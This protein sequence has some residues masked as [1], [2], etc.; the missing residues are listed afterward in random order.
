MLD[1]KFIRENKE[2]VKQAAKKKRIDCDVDK[3][4]EVDEERRV[5]LGR[6]EEK[7]AEQKVASNAIVKASSEE[8]DSILE[9]M[10]TLKE[11]LEREEK[12]LKQV[13]SKWQTMMLAVPNVPDAS[14]PDGD[15]EKDNV[16]VKTWGEKPK[17]D[18]EPKDHVELMIALDMVD[19]ERGT[20]VHGFRGYFLKNAGVLL[21]WA[22]WNYAQHF[23]LQKN[24]VPF[25]APSIVRKSYFYGTGH[26]PNDAE[27]LYKTQD[28]DYLSGTAEVPMMAYHAEEVLNKKDLPKR[29]L[30][31]SPC[32]RREA[33]SYSK[34]V[35]GLIRVHEFFKLEQL[36]LCESSHD[37]SAKLHEEL[38]RN[39]EE[40]IESLGIPYQQLEMCVGDLKGAHVKS[41]DT[42]LWVPKEG[43][44]REIASA[45]YYHD[46][47][48]RRF[49]IRYKDD[50]GKLKYTHSLNAT[51]IP[52]P[53]IL[54]SLIENF[55]QADGSI[56]IPEVLVP[57]MNGLAVIASTSSLQVKK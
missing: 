48:T 20:K 9:K 38:N 49:N 53:R 2:L 33:G 21:S 1:I 43:K 54:V 40:F 25:I 52:T 24:F 26:L 30:A 5:L 17:F 46:F 42:E 18:F 55:Q 19:F 51:A 13:M 56:K 6:V 12:K 36:V 31:F 11:G 35:K 16:V 45:S 15:G 37:E 10:K 8:R 7:R 3:L 14:V 44:Y 39:T 22:I 41:Y 4:I 57:Y 27:D 28:D 32:F 34:D 23:F 29:Y 50:D 47:Q